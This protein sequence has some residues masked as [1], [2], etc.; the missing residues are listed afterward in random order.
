I[1]GRLEHA[2]EGPSGQPV[3]Q[4]QGSCDPGTAD[5]GDRGVAAGPRELST[6]VPPLDGSV[7]QTARSG[8]RDEAVLRA[9]REEG[10][11]R[12]LDEHEGCGSSVRAAVDFAPGEAHERRRSDRGQHDGQVHVGSGGAGA[13]SS[14][15]GRDK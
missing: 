5:P 14:D 4:K 1:S 12:P 13:G 6:V 15:R 11:H 2:A 10:R 7:Q 9:Q 3:L 8:Q